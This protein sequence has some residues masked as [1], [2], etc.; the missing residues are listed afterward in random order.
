MNY[1][2]MGRLAAG[3]GFALC[4]M[5]S[6]CAALDRMEAEEYQRKC[7]SLGISPDSPDFS[8]CILQ[9]QEIEE[10]SLQHSLDRQAVKK[11]H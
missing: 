5:S 6:G 3:I 7:V 1:S 9:Q 10:Q 2:D 11:R 4:V 8:K